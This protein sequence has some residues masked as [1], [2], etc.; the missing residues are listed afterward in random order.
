MGHVSFWSMLMMF[1]HYVKTSIYKKA[2]LIGWFAVQG[3]WALC[4]NIL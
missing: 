2:M 4:D 3:F 1:I